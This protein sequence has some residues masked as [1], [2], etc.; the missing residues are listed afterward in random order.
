MRVLPLLTG[1]SFTGSLHEV[2]GISWVM[3]CSV[4][5]D[6]KTRLDFKAR[7]YICVMES[8]NKNWIQT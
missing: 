4:R 5:F 7:H 8:P 1:Y 3:R 2:A 6:F